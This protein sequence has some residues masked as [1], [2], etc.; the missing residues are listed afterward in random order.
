MMMD[1]HA[2]ASEHAGHMMH[3]DSATMQQ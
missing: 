1:D 2:G 3:S